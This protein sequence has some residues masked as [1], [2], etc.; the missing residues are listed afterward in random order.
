MATHY[1]KQHKY[2]DEILGK[3]LR[4]EGFWYEIRHF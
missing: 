3:G 1:F 2:I 4:R